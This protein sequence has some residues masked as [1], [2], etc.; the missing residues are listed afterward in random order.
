[1]IED[2]IFDG[3]TIVVK[4]QAVANNGQTVVALVE[5]E[6][7]VKTFFKKKGAVELHPANSSMEPFV[8][9][10]GDVKI[11]GIVVGLLRNYY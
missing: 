7:T 8:Y 5:N 2:G 11:E 1:M 10:K 6:A 3:D 4:K 9:S